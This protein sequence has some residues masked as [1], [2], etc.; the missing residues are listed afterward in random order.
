M[1]GCPDENLLT[2]LGEEGALDPEQR[3]AIDHHLDGCAPCSRLVRELATLAAPSRSVPPRYRIIRQLGEG[4]MGV[5]WEA[6]DTNLRRRVALKF[7]RDDARSGSDAGARRARLF[8][9]ARALAQLRHPNVVSVYDAGEVAGDRGEPELFL[10]LELVAGANA[11]AWRDAAQRTPDEILAVWRQ[12]AAGLAAVHRAGLVHR[13]IKP[14]NVFVADDGRVRVGD[15]GLAIGELTNATA[16]TASG[17]V[18]GTPL[19]M[20]PEQLD[21]DP[22]TAKSDQFALCIAIWEA[23]AGAR[24]FP[25]TTIAALAIAMSKRPAI[26]RGA[27]PRHVFAALARGLDPDPARRFTDIDELLAALDDRD[28]RDHGA[29]RPVSSRRT[30]AGALGAAALA[31]AGTLVVLSLVSGP[32]ADSPTTAASAPIAT[33]EPARQVAA[34]QAV[35]PAAATTLPPPATLASDP[36]LAPPADPAVTA[37]SSTKRASKQPA[38][39]RLSSTP[40]PAPSNRER[41]ASTVPPNVETAHADDATE[42]G[43][44]YHTISR[45]TD[46]L[47][48]GDGA[49]CLKLLDTLPK[50]PDDQGDDAKLVRMRCR[51]ALGKCVEATAELT[52]FGKARGWSDTRIAQTIER[53]DAQY[54]PLD[55]AP[56][57]RWPARAKDRLRRAAASDGTCTAILAIMNK[58]GIALDDAREQLR[59]EAA[60][61][62]NAGDCTAAKA[63]YRAFVLHGQTPTASSAPYLEKVV[64]DTFPKQFKRCAP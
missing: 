1:T 61:L 9:E 33:L 62:A 47:H 11:R 16:L 22:A 5:V 4:A 36:P 44:W 59:L 39:G 13:D 31:A 7:V 53:D 6:E 48:F 60:C 52:A 40:T 10:A 63:K 55:A 58:R 27:T 14:D 30:L 35:T 49:G 56:S 17:A 50:V 42:T 64:E 21:G 15:F 2:L 46:R 29:R 20:A 37:S 38:R 23:L 34:A 45:A 26:P 12:A 28:P 41:L 3:A 18:V 57:S 8:R 25:G 24:P 19:Y 51:M 43:D 54:C 32:D